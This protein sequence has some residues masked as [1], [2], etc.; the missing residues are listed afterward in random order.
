MLWIS[1]IDIFWIYSLCIQVCVETDILFCGGMFFY[2]WAPCRCNWGSSLRKQSPL[3][4]C[5]SRGILEAILSFHSH[6]SSAS[7]LQYRFAY[8]HNNFG[9]LVWQQYLALGFQVFELLP[10]TVVHSCN[11]SCLRVKAWGLQ[12]QGH[13]GNLATPCL[14]MKYKKCWG[15][16]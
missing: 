11:S 14:K 7:E 8:K 2:L 5:H 12:V 1:R 9:E 6:V 13:L 16:S 3:L 4:I 10:G 15:Y